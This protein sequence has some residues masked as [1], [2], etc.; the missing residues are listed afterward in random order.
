MSPSYSITKAILLDI[1]ENLS[2]MIIS[3]EYAT[4]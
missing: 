4:S 1:F 3:S 2:P